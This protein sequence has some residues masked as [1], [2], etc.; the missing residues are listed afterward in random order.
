MTLSETLTQAIRTVPDYPEPG[1][2]FKD[3]TPILA[4]P[5]LHRRRDGRAV[6]RP[7]DYQSPRH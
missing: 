1:I 4:D 2:Q 5:D 3:I 7:G 6:F